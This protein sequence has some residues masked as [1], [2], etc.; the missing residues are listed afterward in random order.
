M[1]SYQEAAQSNQK[2]VVTDLDNKNS[3]RAV[4]E[5]FLES[6][7]R[8][9]YTMNFCQLDG[10]IHALAA[11]PGHARPKDWIPLIFAGDNPAFDTEDE[12]NSIT[13]EL[14]WLYNFHNEQASSGLCQLPVDH[15]YTEA[16][17]DRIDLE[18]WARGF[19][20]GYIVWQNIWDQFLNQNQTTGHLA[21]ILP[22]TILDE[23]DDILATISNVADAEYALHNGVAV[24]ELKL[25]FN[26]LPEQV[27]NYG[28]IGHMVRDCSKVRRLHVV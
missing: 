25:M 9:Q 16:R 19:L 17:A 2:I 3:V 10:Y 1:Q 18:Q 4:L 5:P 26:R 27:I 20:Q 23:L 22:I 14:I 24:D 28:R 15:H 11:G 12:S 6:S 13:K 7:A 8:P 21:A